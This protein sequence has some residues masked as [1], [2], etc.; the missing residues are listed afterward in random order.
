MLEKFRGLTQGWLAKLILALITVP[1]ALWGIDSYLQ[2]A[3]SKVAVAEVDGQSVTVQEFGNAMQNLR[4]QLQAEGKKDPALLDNPAVKRSVLDELVT[5]KLLSAEVRRSGFAL[6]NESLSN[7]II[8]LPEFQKEGKFSQEHYDSILAQNRLSPSQFEARMRNEL[9]VQQARDGIAAAAFTPDAVLDS[10]IKIEQQ[11]REVSVANIRADEFLS[12]A[13]VDA[14]Q[15]KEYYDKHQDRL[16]VPEQVKIEYVLFSANNLI[17]KMQVTDE[18]MRKYYA[19]NAGKFQGDE[20]RRASHILI[21]FGGK[22]DEKSKAAAREKA[23]AVLAEVKKNPDDFAALAKKYSQ[24]PGSAQNGGDLGAFGRGMM[25]KPFEDTVFSLAPGAISDLVETEFGYHI[26]KLT[27]IE[28]QSQ[29]YDDVKANIRAELMY[30]KALAK[31][32]EQAENFSNLVYEQYDSLKPAADALDLQVQTSAWMSRDDAMKFFKNDKLVGAI[33]SDE[34]LK[35]G[36]NTEAVE[37]AANTM[38]SARVV[39]H[40]PSTVRSL[41]EVSA[42]LEKFLKHQQ[43]VEMANKKGAE[44]LDA[45]RQGKDAGTVE[46]MPA[47]VVDRKNA[48]GLSGAVLQQA[49]K[50]DS[51]KL[52]AFGGVENRN[53]YT[54]I[55]VSRV[56]SPAVE[57]EDEKNFLQGGVQS[58]QSEEYLTAY[59][60]S[61]K[62]KAK[63]KVNESLLGTGAQ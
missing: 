37:V 57:D 1:F 17:P 34:V 60:A 20:R 27:G 52:P 30:Q 45:L 49:F 40:K 3:G 58:A 19:E 26:I 14:A 46:W 15:V 50:I 5:S 29:G 9:L 33:F 11:Q 10:T 24:D 2:G 44:V 16:R 48:E 4:Y 21:G 55:R 18:E 28:G 22:T 47:V 63:I 56:D 12:Q 54:L 41:E 61:L 59:L 6:S 13:K 32:A 53:G 31:F 39:D 36:R 8:T 23:L 51:E 62:G 25:V 35:D 38:L 7:Y 42:D 43:A